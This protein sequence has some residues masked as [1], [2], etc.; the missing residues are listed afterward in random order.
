MQ[1]PTPTPKK[2]RR[3]AT[4]KLD[5]IQAAARVFARLGYHGSSL[6]DV[7]NELGITP[8]ALYYYVRSKD[9]LLMEAT[10]YASGKIEKRFLEICDD[11]DSSSLR[12]LLLYFRF[13]AECMTDDF[14]RCLALTSPNDLPSPLREA[15]LEQRREL[16]D[17]VRR[18]IREGIADGSIQPCD[19][20]LLA[21]TL[22]AAANM[23]ARWYSSSGPQTAG[24]LM[25]GIL[26]MLVNGLIHPPLPD[27]FPG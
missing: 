13:Y 17:M 5:V 19:D 1:S 8:A 11:K 16:T 14:G 2:K 3:Y 23:L 12:K 6:N 4:R 26:M 22:Y 18:L 27:G 7:A 10:A 20:R 15:S 25:D 21:F 24:E 9:E